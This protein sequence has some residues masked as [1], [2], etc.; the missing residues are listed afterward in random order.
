[1]V[2]SNPLVKAVPSALYEGPGTRSVTWYVAMGARSGASI[3]DQGAAAAVSFLASV[4]IGR[5]LG[6]EALG[7]YAMT[8]VFVTLIRTLQDCVVLEPMAVYGPRRTSEERSGYFGFLL[9]LETIWVG[10]LT[11]LLAAGSAFAWSAE[12]IDEQ[13]FHAIVASSGF[14]FIFCFL[15][16]RR[17]QFY[18]ELHQFRALAQSLSYLLLVVA[19][20]VILS[21]FKS[22][23]I[24]DI[25]AVLALCSAVACI[26]GRDRINH[27]YSQPSRAEIRRYAGEH[28]SFGKWVL[29]GIPLG[30]AAYH[31]YFFFIGAI[32]STEAAG[33]L[34]AA[35][36]LVA[37]FFQIAMGMRLMLTPMASR[38]IDRMS[39]SQRRAYVVRIA[40]PLLGVATTYGIAVYFGGELALRLLFRDQIEA[41]Y[42]LVPIMAFIPVFI[43]APLPA[44]I[45]LSALGQAN[46]RFISQCIACAGTLIV[47]LP[48]VWHYGL[49]G[50]AVALVVTEVLFA[51]GHWGCLLWLLQGGAKRVG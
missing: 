30:M 23:S 48:L 47:G 2:E 8:N 10:F 28:W 6:T 37:P 25:Y 13:L 51:M 24:V 16:F 49:I 29:L 21:F 39:G 34:K 19:A 43:A 27:R 4:Y 17:R 45:A 42:P 36:T 31:G 22:T 7:I 11:T 1:M 20:F 12:R 15:Y 32:V 40:V 26:V 50:G 9:G 33:L 35:E 18:V 38:E 14:S 3:A 46:M 41:A 44:V 5:Q